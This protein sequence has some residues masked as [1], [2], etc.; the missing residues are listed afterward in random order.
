[1]KIS[2]TSIS[3]GRVTA[4]RTVKTGRMKSTALPFSLLYR[5]LSELLVIVETPP[6]LSAQMAIVCHFGGGVTV[7]T[8]VMTVKMR[9]IA[10]YCSIM[11]VHQTSF[12]AI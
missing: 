9:R 11:P 8:I 2:G 12:T 7:T 3:C 10:T 5:R 1:M 6:C 4:I